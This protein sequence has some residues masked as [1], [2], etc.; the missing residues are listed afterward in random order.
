[1]PMTISQQQ[2][3]VSLLQDGDVSTIGLIKGKLLEGG[4]ARLARTA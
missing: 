4:Q 2:A 1:M 3:L